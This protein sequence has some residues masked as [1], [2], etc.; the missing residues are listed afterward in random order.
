MFLAVTRLPPMKRPGRML[1]FVVV[2][3]GLATIGFGLSTSF[4]LSMACLFLTGIFD[5]ISVLI[6]QTLEQVVT[7]DRLRGRVSAINYVFIGFSN[8]FGAFE[9]G[10]TAA[11]FGPIASVVGGGVGTILVV[12]AVIMAWPALAR[13]GPLHTLK[14]EEEAD[15]ISA[16]EARHSV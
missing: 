16:T 15:I 1:L 12:L 4:V 8:E 7:P 14:P 9:S 13:I 6:R 11:L 5:S 10:A 2:G 3:F